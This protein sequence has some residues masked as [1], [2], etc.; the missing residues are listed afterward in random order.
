MNDDYYAIHALNN[1]D[2]L[3]SKIRD[4]YD[5]DLLT[6]ADLKYIAIRLEWLLKDQLAKRADIREEDRLAKQRGLEARDR[7]ALRKAATQDSSPT[8]EVEA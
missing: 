4:C 6:D 7:A 5:G 3:V 2:D 1:L 8:P